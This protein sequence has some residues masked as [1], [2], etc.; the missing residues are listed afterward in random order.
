VIRFLKWCRPDPDTYEA[1][2]T[3]RQYVVGFIVGALEFLFVCSVIGA[4]GGIVW[5]LIRLIAREIS[6]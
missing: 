2:P 6:K 5:G 1:E 3:R 4:G